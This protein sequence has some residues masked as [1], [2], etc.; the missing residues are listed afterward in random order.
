MEF[1]VHVYARDWKISELENSPEQ[2]GRD[3]PQHDARVF[4]SPSNGARYGTSWLADCL[5]ALVQASGDYRTP[6]GL[7][8]SEAATTND[9][10][11]LVYPSRDEANNVG[12]WRNMVRYAHSLPVRIRAMCAYVDDNY[13]PEV[14]GR[15]RTAM[16]CR[17]AKC[18]ESLEQAQQ[19]R[20]AAWN[21]DHEFMLNNGG[22]SG[23]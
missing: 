11:A 21:R 13:Q 16:E 22:S 12:L 1:A 4:T 14:A 17:D 23:W 9:P 19:D 10:P 7:I 18:G 20:L 6:N 8:V 5:H 3:E 15:E 2:N